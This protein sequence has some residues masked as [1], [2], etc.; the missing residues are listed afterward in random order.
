[1]RS[2]GTAALAAVALV[3][4]A[5]SSTYKASPQMDY[6]HGPNVPEG[7][8]SVLKASPGEITFEVRI[9]FPSKQMYHLVLDGNTPVAEGWFST[10]RAGG[11]SYE[12]TLKP[13]QGLLYEAGKT[14]RL[15]IGSQNPQQVQMTSSS[16]QCLV[17][18][19]FVL[20]LTT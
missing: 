17:D 10:V 4:A 15:C 12:V 19:T 20:E 11:E 8:V 5:C 1:M 14:Y 16:Y 7:H 6:Y 18:H 9:K 13:K 3:L 2:M